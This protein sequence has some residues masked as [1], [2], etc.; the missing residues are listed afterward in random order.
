MEGE[1]GK[2][3]FAISLSHS[4]SSPAKFS[5]SQVKH[6]EL[7]NATR[8]RAAE[9]RREGRRKEVSPFLTLLTFCA[10]TDTHWGARLTRPPFLFRGCKRLQCNLQPRMLHDKKLQKRLEASVAH[11]K[12]SVLVGKPCPLSSITLSD[13]LMRVPPAQKERRRRGAL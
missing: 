7:A 10:P 8:R 5:A 6:A 2:A 3:A 13:E 9:E 12:R 11:G 4:L 1:N